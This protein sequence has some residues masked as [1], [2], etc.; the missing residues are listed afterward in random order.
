[1]PVWIRP[2]LVCFRADPESYQVYHRPQNYS[3]SQVAES[4]EIMLQA[5]VFVSLNLLV[6][7]GFTDS[8]RKCRP[9]LIFC[10]TS[11]AHGKLQSQH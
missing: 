2:G 3:F 7:L 9:Y 4:V 10:D 8:R 11:S 5:G 1:M 6:F